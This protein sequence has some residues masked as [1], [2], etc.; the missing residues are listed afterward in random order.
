MA[1]ESQTLRYVNWRELFPF[2]HL[3]RSFRVAIHPSKLFLGLLLVLLLYAGGRVLDAAWMRAYYPSYDEMDRFTA[4]KWAQERGRSFDAVR[5]DLRQANLNQYASR[6]KAAGIVTDDQAAMDAARHGKYSSDLERRIITG[7]NEAIEAADK[8]LNDELMQADK[9]T[10]ETDKEIRRREARDQHDSAVR[11]AQEQTAVELENLARL[12]P[13]PIFDEFMDYEARQFHYVVENAVSWNWL[14][15]LTT[16][17]ASEMATFTR[18][19]PLDNEL[20]AAALAFSRPGSVVQ[21][22]SNFAVVGPGWLVRYHLLYFVL[23]A[24]WFLLMWAI[25]GGAIARIAAVHVARD[26]KISVR[27]AL[28][29]S[30]SKV[31]SF[32]FAPVIPLI[33]IL[34]VGIVVAIGGL[35]MYVPVIG[36]IAVGAFFV[37]ALLAGFVMTLVVVGTAGG[38]NLMYPTVAVEGSDSFDAISRSFSYIFARPWRMIFYTVVSMVYGALTFIFCRYFVYVMLGLTHFFVGWW[39]VGR[40]GRYWPEIWPPVSDYSLAYHV[41]FP[42]LAVSERIAAV[43][44]ALWVYVILGLLAGYV[45]SFYFSSNTI[46]YFLMRREVD[47]TE[48]DDVYL[49]ETDDDFG[50]AAA[51]AAAPGIET[52][53]TQTTTTTVVTGSADAGSN[54]PPAAEPGGT[55]S[56][57]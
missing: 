11:Q 39:L 9:A 41:V 16:R 48:M 56:G 45:V 19:N 27:Q 54:P 6:L 26:E 3:F 28:R 8:R 12:A 43:L 32:I 38:F 4:Y 24:C 15:G 40:A 22:V 18:G 20:G 25:F 52:V 57:S 29:F 36:P 34:V 7:R 35:L 10:N 55:N 50:E 14:N 2:T 47:A 5:E 37:L 30:T 21:A 53:T 33:I 44:I 51:A 42:A 1:D 13:R 49:E 23:Y 17:G 31:L 46:I